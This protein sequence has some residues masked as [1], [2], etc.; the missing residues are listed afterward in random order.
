MYLLLSYVYPIITSHLIICFS[1][2]TICL[3]DLIFICQDMKRDPCTCDGI[4]GNWIHGDC[5]YSYYPVLVYLRAVLITSI[6]RCSGLKA[7]QVH[8]LIKLIKTSSIILVF[9]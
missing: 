7:V 9:F 1:H 6:G 5:N 8:F 2:S 3:A 4:V